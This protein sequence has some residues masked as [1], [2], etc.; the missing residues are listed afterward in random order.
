MNWVILSLIVLYLTLGLWNVRYHSRGAITFIKQIW[1]EGPKWLVLLFLLVHLVLVG[2]L[3]LVW[4][5]LWIPY[6]L[7]KK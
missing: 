4:P 7:K 1:E 6:L 5:V 3:W 2:I